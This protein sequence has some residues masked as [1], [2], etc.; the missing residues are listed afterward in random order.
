MT[1]DSAHAAAIVAGRVYPDDLNGI[2]FGT[3]SGRIKYATSLRALR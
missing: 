2:Q 1:A 3:N